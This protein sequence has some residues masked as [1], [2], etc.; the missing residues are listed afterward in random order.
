MKQHDLRQRQGFTLI[1]L[2]IVVAIIAI[3]AAIALPSLLGAKKNANE[4]AAIAA[5]RAIG[6]SCEQY[7]TSLVPASYPPNLLA[8]TVAGGAATDY[9]DSVLAAGQKSGYVYNLV[10][11]NANALG[12][13]TT[14][15]CWA[16]PFGPESGNRAFFLDE[17][18]VIRQVMGM[19]PAGPADQPIE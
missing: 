14:Y 8:L 15:Q 19:G 5:L 11:A 16:S 7:R 1:E 3:I 2:M 9:I 12:G 10:G 18:G 4:S 17:S 13:L 6:T